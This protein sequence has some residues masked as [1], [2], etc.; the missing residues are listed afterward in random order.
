VAVEQVG[1]HLAVI[2]RDVAEPF[3]DVIAF[4]QADFHI[5]ILAALPIAHYTLPIDWQGKRLG[6]KPSCET[7]G[8]V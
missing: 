8:N 1:E 5:E 6:E 7:M 3:E 2:A 4:E